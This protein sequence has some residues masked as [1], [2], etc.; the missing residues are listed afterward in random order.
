MEGYREHGGAGTSP[1]GVRALPL[2]VD[3]ANADD[4]A[5]MIEK[6]VKELGRVDILIN[7]AA[8]ARGPDRVPTIELDDDIFQKVVDIKIRGTYLC[9]KAVAKVLIAQGTG[10]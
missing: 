10:R 6:T 3:V 9:T 7:N 2:V 5:E 1:G 4:V 8:F